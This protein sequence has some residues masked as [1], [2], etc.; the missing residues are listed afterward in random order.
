MVAY[1]PASSVA[2][3]A[4]PV[5]IPVCAPYRR[6]SPGGYGFSHFLCTFPHGWGGVSLEIRLPRQRLRQ[7]A[8]VTTVQPQPEVGTGHLRLH[9]LDTMLPQP[10]GIVLI[11]VLHVFGLVIPHEVQELE[12][13][14][15]VALLVARN[16]L[17][18]FSSHLLVLCAVGG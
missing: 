13:G 15:G 2:R 10:P 11:F 17:S 14:G 8:I 9:S 1:S 6:L 12:I 3:A 16:N 7:A 4:S 5:C 18:N